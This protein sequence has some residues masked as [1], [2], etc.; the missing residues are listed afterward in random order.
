MIAQYLGYK[1]KILF[2]ICVLNCSENPIP[3]LS[4]YYSATSVD[5]I[6]YITDTF[7][8]LSDTSKEIFPKKILSLKQ[9]LT[10]YQYIMLDFAL[11][12]YKLAA[13]KYYNVKKMGLK[14][15][16]ELFISEQRLFTFNKLNFSAYIVKGFMSVSSIIG[17]LFIVHNNL[18]FDRIFLLIDIIYNFIY[19]GAKS[20]A[21]FWETVINSTMPTTNNTHSPSNP[22]ILLGQAKNLT[23]IRTMKTGIQKNFIKTV[24]IQI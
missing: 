15:I 17:L 19:T 24:Q 7:S 6:S 4:D 20:A 23:E 22:K 9:F 21:G 8:Y 11:P 5:N 12:S 14:R 3:E 18:I 13:F 10:D 16:Y 1:D 2:A